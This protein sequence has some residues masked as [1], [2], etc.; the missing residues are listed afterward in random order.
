[1]YPLI[2]GPEELL[3]ANRHLESVKRALRAEGTAF[4]ED[5]EV[6]AMIEVPAAVMVGDILAQYVDFFSIG[7]NDLIQYSIA[8][9]RV[10]EKIAHLYEPAHPGVLRMVRLIVGA[11]K[12]GGIWVGMCGEMAADPGF[13]L[14]LLGMGLDELSVAAIAIPEIK[15]LIRAAT[16]RDAQELADRVLS[17][18]SAEQIRREID[19]TVNRLAPELPRQGMSVSG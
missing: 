7:T 11:A 18:R 17:L 9:D 4:D 12:A 16:Y 15:L 6:G 3:E 19:K 13:A 14:V 2:S 1:M 10:N 8:V 5:I